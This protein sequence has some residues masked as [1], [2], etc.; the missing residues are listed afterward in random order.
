MSFE[1]AGG[2]GLLIAADVATSTI[3]SFEHPEWV[4]GFDTLPE[5]AIRTRQRFLDRAAT[6]REKVL[7]YHWSYPGVGYAER[8][9]STF[10]FLPSL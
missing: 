1:L 6:D 10:R 2:D 4:F 8:Y 9:G 7:G 3:V 5:V